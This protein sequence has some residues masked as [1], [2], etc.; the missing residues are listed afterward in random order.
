MNASIFYSPSAHVTTNCW[1]RRVSGIRTDFSNRHQTPKKRATAVVTKALR[2]DNLVRHGSIVQSVMVKN[3][4]I[5]SVRGLSGEVFLWF[6]RFV[7]WRAFDGRC[8]PRRRSGRQWFAVGTINVIAVV[9]GVI[10]GWW[11]W[12]VSK[13]VLRGGD[14]SRFL[15]IVV[16]E[17]LL[18]VVLPKAR[19]TCQQR[20]YGCWHKQVEE[21]G[22]FYETEKIILYC[23]CVTMRN[24][25]ICFFDKG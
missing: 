3:A 2:N 10:F 22:A 17:R 16:D 15:G 9:R 20:H 4:Y 13:S 18:A 7:V 24:E 19:M 25:N 21:G 6:E 23:Y 11:S 5:R 14:G 8:R 12:R 1:A